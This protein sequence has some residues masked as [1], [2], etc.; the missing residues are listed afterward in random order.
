MYRPSRRTLQRGTKGID[1]WESYYNEFLDKL[2][3]AGIDDLKAEAQKQVDAY[4]K[5]NHSTWSPQE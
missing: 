5:A 2:R 3:A 1:G 4:V